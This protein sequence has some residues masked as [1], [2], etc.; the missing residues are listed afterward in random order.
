MGD[1]LLLTPV[2]PALKKK[3][4]QSRIIVYCRLRSRM[5]VFRNNPYIDRLLYMSPFFR[6]S[7]MVLHRHFRGIKLYNPEYGQLRPGLFCRKHASEIIAEEFFGIQL[8][9]NRAQIYLT[10]SEERTAMEELSRYNRPVMI[11]PG[12]VST[13]NKMWPLPRWEEL[14]KR[15]PEYTFIQLGLPTEDRVEGAVDLRGTSFRE[16][17]GLIKHARGF[18]GIDSSFAHATSAFG[19]PGVV[20]FG[21]STPD[22]WGHPNN[23][24]IYGRQRCSPC[25]ELLSDIKCPYDKICMSVITV[26]EVVEAL[27]MQLQLKIHGIYAERI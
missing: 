17:L 16:A 27:K 13:A 14:V 10:L 26:D 18:V 20:L 9:D 4:P 15:M 24:N 11:H 23:V 25:I 12:T 22:V 19:I 2:F 21:P 1:L 6:T 8:E 5:D 3:Y 7:L